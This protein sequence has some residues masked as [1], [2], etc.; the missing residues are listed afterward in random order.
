M[1]TGIK[2]Y[3][4]T[5]GVKKDA[6]QEEIKKAYR[7]LA[8]KYHPDLNPGDK[9]AEQRFKDVNEAYEVLG[10]PKKRDDYDRLGKSPFEAGGPGFEGFRTYDFTGTGFDFG[11]GF[12]NVFSDLFRT[13]RMGPSRG[14]DTVMSMEISLE[15]A[16]FGA[17]KPVTVTREVNCKACGGTGAEAFQTC[18][19][20]KGTGK[21]KASRGFFSLSQTCPDCGGTGRKVSKACKTCGGKGTVSTRETINVKI[22]AGVDNGSRVRLS[23]FGEPGEA[24]GP[25]GALYIEIK[26]I[27]HYIFRREGDDIFVDVP[28]TMPEAVLG[29][30]IEVPTIDGMASVNLPAGTNSG[31]KLRLKAKGIAHLKGGGRGDQYAIIKIV[32][33]P[34]QRLAE[35]QK[36]AIREIGDAYIENP[37]KGLVYRG[38]G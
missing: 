27:P 15:D 32:S 4:E 38:R 26:V 5:L 34:P 3:Y 31:Q 21:L 18:P 12:E 33:P 16:A 2:D 25:S 17:T 29:A 37:R 10:D 7:R 22:P 19:A 11:G 36:E 20:C 1:P 28:V 6:T 9:V 13:G 24:G 14:G 8:R 35:R 23:G 30:K